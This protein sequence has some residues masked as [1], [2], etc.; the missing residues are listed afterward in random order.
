MQLYQHKGYI[1]YNKGYV[2]IHKKKPEIQNPQVKDKGTD[3]WL[4]KCKDNI[5]KRNLR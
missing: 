2:C 4:F 3:S 5:W 1:P